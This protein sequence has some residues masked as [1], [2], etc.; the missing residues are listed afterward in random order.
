MCTTSSGAS[1]LVRVGV[2]VR[3]SVRARARAR[4]RVRGRGRG[5][6]RVRVRVNLVAL[7]AREGHRRGP[8]RGDGGVVVV[9]GHGRGGRPQP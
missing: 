5:R 6:V 1:H 8:S 9:V 2:R 7:V 3:A 4:A